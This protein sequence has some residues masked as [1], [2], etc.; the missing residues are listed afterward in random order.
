MATQV[1][2]ARRDVDV[3]QVVDDSALDVI[4]DAVDQVAT[5]HVHDLYV[6]QIPGNNRKQDKE[7]PADVCWF[8]WK[9]C[10]L[11]TCPEPHP[12]AGRKTRNT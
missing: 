4:E 11:L 5:A 1:D 12:E 10:C 6:G 3:H 9:S 8:R 7:V 2:G